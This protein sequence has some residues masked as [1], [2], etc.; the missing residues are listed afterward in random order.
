M[1]R[2]ITKK[3]RRRPTLADIA[4]ELGLSAA[5]VSL[6]LNGFPLVAEKTARRV[7]EA[8]K[9]HNYRPNAIARRLSVGHS[10]VISFYVLGGKDAALGFLP[11][12]WMF[13]NPILKGASMALT[14]YRYHLQFEILSAELGDQCDTIIEHILGGATDGVLLLYFDDYLPV[15]ADELEKVDVP[16]VTMNRKVSPELSSAQVDNRSGAIAAV[17]YLKE[18]GHTK[19]A[20]I[21]GPEASFNARD[22]RTG[23]LEAMAAAGLDVSDGYLLEGDWQ[24]QSGYYLLREMMMLPDP[25]T[26]VFCSNDYMAMGALEALRDLNIAVPEQVSI[27]GFDD[28]E[29]SRVV[30][31]R[32]TTVRQPLEELGRRAAEEVMALKG[33]GEHEIRHQVIAPELVR[34]GSC[35]SPSLV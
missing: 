27:I 25:P 24:T 20:H 21:S 22:R 17:E 33:D 4:A 5:T 32:L 31:P 8:A 18:L 1:H 19:I 2:E 34:R 16:I 6:A 7:R 29:I 9:K 3:S 12:S 23:Y 10:E 30:L 13:Y 26:A 35:A 14:R 15:V 11:S 28:S